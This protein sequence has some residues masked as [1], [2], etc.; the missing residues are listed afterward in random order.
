MSSAAGKPDQ[1]KVAR[2]A[3]YDLI[4]IIGRG[5]YGTV[6]VGRHRSGTLRAVKVVE[7]FPGNPGEREERALWA[8]QQR[9]NRDPHLV[10][11]LDIA[12]DDRHLIY[13]M[14]L[15]DPATG[16]PPET[17]DY[18]P[19]TLAWRI[20]SRGRLSVREAVRLG[21]DLLSA[22]AALHRAELVH[23]DVKPANVIFVNG[24]PKL[25]DIGLAA[26]VHTDLSAVGTPGFLPPDG[27]VGPDADLYALGKVLYQAVTGLP[28]SDFP[29]VPADVLCA[30]ERH[31]MRRLNR[32][33]LRACAMTKAERFASADELREA[34]T[35][36]LVPRALW[37][38]RCLV[39]GACLFLCLAAALGFWTWRRPHALPDPIPEPT[40]PAASVPQPRVEEILESLTDAPVDDAF[41][42]TVAALP[43]GDQVRVV[44]AKLQRLN[45][46]FNG[47]LAVNLQDNKVRGLSFAPHLVRDVSP[48]RALA[49]LTSLDCGSNMAG[50]H[51][52]IAD[53]SPLRGLRLKRLR[54]AWNRVTDLSPLAGMPLEYLD[55]SGN[56]VSDL[57][58]LQ[59]LP[60]QELYCHTNQIRDLAPLVG[61]ALV[62]L[63]CGSNPVDDW[64]VLRNLRLQSLSV[65]ET[66]I[67]DLSFIQHMPLEELF[68][69]RSKVT[70]LSPL[71]GLPIRLLNCGGNAITNLEPL[72]KSPLEALWIWNT[73]VDS[74]EPL[75]GKELLELSLTGTKVT[76]LSPL[77]GMPLRRIY[78]TVRPE[79]DLRPLRSLK[80][81]THINDQRAEVFWAEQSK[82]HRPN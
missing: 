5:A 49:D 56:G 2:L 46:G 59:G 80:T 8:V 57:K 14:E 70:D 23:R 77:H 20:A 52:Q 65:F 38:R 11:I 53:L 76:D 18:R 79:I 67:S 15:A 30:P 78:L 54:F 72:R 39:G 3:D 71:R 27:S 66:S 47:R 64:S 6:W 73:L 22:L 32:V 40:T 29:I 60:I 12:H 44:T 24:I 41:V 35:S 81:L 17:D 37:P 45:P 82:Q 62:H 33:L 68:C 75:R 19:D 4:R 74:L 9:V 51:G 36:V 34:L 25:A 61:M 69:Q 16:S 58:P 31:L 10:E 55:L 26:V 43:A 21:L 1:V 13:A 7:R 48:L 28:P 63:N 42:R 50:Q